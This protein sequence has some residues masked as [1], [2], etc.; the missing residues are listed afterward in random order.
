MQRILF[1]NNIINE[2]LYHKEVFAKMKKYC[3]YFTCATVIEELASIPD[4]KIE[5]RVKLFLA[6]ADLEVKF[7]PDSAFIFGKTRLNFGSLSSRE[8]DDVYRSLLKPDGS[9]QNDAIIGA[10]AFTRNCILLTND[11]YLLKAMNRNG[12][13]A[14]SFKEFSR[15]AANMFADC[16]SVER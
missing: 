4:S 14:L 6:F 13:R 16:A 5:D 1:D 8:T 2:I 11:K 10:T 3:E 7:V 12:H 15:E 9:N